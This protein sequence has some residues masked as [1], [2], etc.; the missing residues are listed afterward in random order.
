MSQKF[1]AEAPKRTLHGGDEDLPR[2]EPLHERRL[3]YDSVAAKR[4]A[5]AAE[6]Y[7]DDDDG[8]PD[9]EFFGGGAKRRGARAGEE[10]DFYQETKVG[11][12][13]GGS[14]IRKRGRFWRGLSARTA[15]TCFDEG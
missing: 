7:G 10:D 5:K 6:L 15:C 9:S 8:A 14:F 13:V 12:A 11:A 2:R 4:S 3:K 1:G